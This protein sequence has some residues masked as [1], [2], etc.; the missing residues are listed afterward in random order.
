MELSSS[1]AGGRF[2]AR[3]WAVTLQAV[4][5]FYRSMFPRQPRPP[6]VRMRRHVRAAVAL[7]YRTW[8]DR[9]FEPTAQNIA[10]LR[11]FR[12]DLLALTATTSRLVIRLERRFH[13]EPEVNET[14]WREWSKR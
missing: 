2:A 7:L 1:A 11:A 13:G 14:K 6:L 4:H 9:G 12:Q 3:E 10:T 5:R 8:R